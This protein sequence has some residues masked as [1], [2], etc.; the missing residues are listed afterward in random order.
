M[1]QT[2]K[3]SKIIR[4]PREKVYNAFTEKDALEIW[5]A[6][7][8]MTGK[9]HSFDLRLGGGY[10]MSLFYQDETPG[11]TSGNEDR[12]SSKFVELKPYEKIVQMI[13]FQSDKS[14]YKDEMIMEVSLEEIGNSSTKVTII[15]TNIP[16]GIDPKD[17]EDGTAQSLEKL[18]R[19]LESRGDQGGN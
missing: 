9:I 13:N 16:P 14:E 17:N 12:S 18:A 11:K 4:A 10:D 8:G 7:H 3:N 2:S 19:Y 6:P 1:N 5:L 15:F